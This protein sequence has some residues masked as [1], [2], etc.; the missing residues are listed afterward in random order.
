MTHHE[1]A[2]TTTEVVDG[3]D[4]VVVTCPRGCNLGTSALIPA[5]AHDRDALVE[6]RIALHR[7]ATSSPVSR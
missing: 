7:T 6:N 1:A 3:E 2:V 4:H 5:D